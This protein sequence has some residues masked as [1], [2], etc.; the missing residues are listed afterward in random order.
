MAGECELWFR[1]KSNGRVKN[2]VIANGRRSAD[3]RVFQAWESNSARSCVDG[4]AA[5]YKCYKNTH[6]RNL[7]SI[8]SSIL[9]FLS[10]FI[11]FLLPVLMFPFYFS[12][13][14]NCLYCISWRILFL[15]CWKL[16]KVLFQ[17]M[18]KVIIIIVGRWSRLIMKGY[19]SRTPVG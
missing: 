15:F 1:A 4:S 12:H 16:Y 7:M 11:Y 10:V 13:T 8:S 19:L 2:R 14:C 3:G 17:G 9:V 18:W 6:H 5:R